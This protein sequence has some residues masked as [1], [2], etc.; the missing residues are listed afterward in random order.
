[1]F[2]VRKSSILIKKYVNGLSSSNMKW[3]EISH[4]K[5]PPGPNQSEKKK[6]GSH[7]YFNIYNKFKEQSINW[8]P[9]SLKISISSKKSR[10]QLHVK[11][12]INMNMQK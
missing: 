4:F 9:V 1:M 12:N 10:I 5:N 7:R 8:I 6:Q 3:I 11:V 2:G